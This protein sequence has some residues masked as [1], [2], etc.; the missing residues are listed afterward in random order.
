MRW[1]LAYWL[2]PVEHIEVYRYHLEKIGHSL[3][4]GALFAPTLS[5]LG[6]SFP[7]TTLLAAIAYLVV[8]K[9]LVR[10]HFSMDWSADALIGSGSVPLACLAVGDVRRGAPIMLAIVALY[11]VAVLWKRRASP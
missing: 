9:H 6:L 10:S 1:L 3:M 8:G 5:H 4:L 11:V 2:R 7:Q